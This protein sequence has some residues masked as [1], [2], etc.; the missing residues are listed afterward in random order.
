M[1]EKLDNNDIDLDEITLA[2][3]NQLSQQNNSS[4]S[5]YY[6]LYCLYNNNLKDA[7]TYLLSAVNSTE[8]IEASYFE[9]LS[10]LGLVE[11][12]LYDSRGGLNRCYEASN[13]FSTIPELYINLAH[14]EL[15]LGN[16]RRGIIAI[17]QCLEYNPKF[18][19]KKR[20]KEC[21]G[22]RKANH[23]KK[24]NHRKSILGKFLRKKKNQCLA[25]TINNILND[26]LSDKLELYIKQ[27]S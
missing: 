10:F 27:N 24:I 11:V 17:E 12:L 23:F 26:M 15:T 16:R 6:G 4:E 2:D 22:K 18:I 25:N 13:D 7:N 8:Q 3:F 1:L 21:I 5:F 9:Y 20:L 14:A 19:Y